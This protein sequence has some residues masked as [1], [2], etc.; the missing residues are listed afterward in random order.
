LNAL[1]VDFLA[2]RGRQENVIVGSSATVEFIESR[3][4]AEGVVYYVSPFPD[5]ETNTYT[6][7]VRVANHDGELNAGER[8]RLIRTDLPDGDVRANS[9][10]DDHAA[11]SAAGR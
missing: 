7:K 3:R 11:S 10:A 2:P 1:S 6:V 8:C 9:G 4:R 5:G